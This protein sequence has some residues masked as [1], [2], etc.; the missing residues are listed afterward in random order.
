M[1]PVEMVDH[2]A[3]GWN[4]FDASH[5]HI[6]ESTT[7]EGLLSTMYA[8]TVDGLLAP[9]HGHSNPLFGPPDSHLDGRSIAPSAKALLDMGV[10]TT[11]VQQESLPQVANDALSNGWKIKDLTDST[12]GANNN[13][14]PGFRQIG[15]ILPQHANVPQGTEEGFVKQV[16]WSANFLNVI[17]K[18]PYAAFSYAFVEFFFLRGGVDWYKEDIEEEGTAVFVEF[19]SVTVVRLVAFTIISIITLAIFG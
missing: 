8:T 9:A 19:A 13:V 11:T 5:A 15:G 14:L 18:I 4:L 7:F 3:S 16:Q 10:Q 17:D 6:H 1:H 12:I 2:V